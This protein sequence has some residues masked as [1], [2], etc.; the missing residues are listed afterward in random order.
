MKCSGIFQRT[1]KN[2]IKFIQISIKPCKEKQRLELIGKIRNFNE[3]Q[4]I[5]IILAVRLIC[6]IFET[7]LNRLGLEQK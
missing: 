7:V 1:F 4:T 5:S 3:F 6:D 2:S